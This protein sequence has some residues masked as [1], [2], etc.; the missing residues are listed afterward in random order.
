MYMVYLNLKLNRIKQV[1]WYQEWDH[2]QCYHLKGNSTLLVMESFNKSLLIQNLYNF[3]K[4]ASLYKHKMGHTSEGF[5]NCFLIKCI[6]KKQLVH[7]SI[8]TCKNVTVVLITGTDYYCCEMQLSPGV[9]IVCPI[10]I[11]YYFYLW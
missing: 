3:Y 5:V 9:K 2:T 8:I 4:V 10:L 11:W 1:E 6:R 7:Y